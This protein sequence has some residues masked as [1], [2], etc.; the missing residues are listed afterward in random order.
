MPGGSGGIPGGMPCGKPGKFGGGKGGA[1]LAFGGGGPWPW[2][3]GG[4]GKDP[5]AMSCARREGSMPLKGGI[6]APP[7]FGGGGKGIP[8][9]GGGIGGWFVPPIPGRELEVPS[10]AVLSPGSERPGGRKPPPGFFEGIF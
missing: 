8:P 7:A 6:G 1:P 9:G 10:G 4:G 2:G 5:D 3:I